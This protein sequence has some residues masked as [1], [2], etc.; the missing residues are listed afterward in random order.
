MT[1]SMTWMCLFSFFLTQLLVSSSNYVISD[2][3]FRNS[4]YL[5][6]PPWI[7]G[8][9]ILIQHCHWIELTTIDSIYKLWQIFNT[10]LVTSLMLGKKF[11][12]RHIIDYCCCRLWQ[13]VRPCPWSRTPC[14]D[15]ARQECTTLTIYSSRLSQVWEIR[16][17]GLLTTSSTQVSCQGTCISNISVNVADWIRSP[18]HALDQASPYEDP[19][20]SRI[21][22]GSQ[23]IYRSYEGLSSG[24]R[25]YEDPV[26]STSINTSESSRHC[27]IYISRISSG[28]RSYEDPVDQDRILRDHQ[29]DSPTDSVQ[30]L[31]LKFTFALSS[32]QL[33]LNPVNARTHTILLP[34]LRRESQVCSRQTWVGTFPPQYFFNTLFLSSHMYPENLEKQWSNLK[35][36]EL[37]CFLS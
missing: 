35:L 32:I 3:P 23:W 17:P 18:I 34:L 12:R 6:R 21:I 27:K 22:R 16:R 2:N 24:S 10:G 20:R 8:Y 1:W 5:L 36:Y 19:V 37:V 33:C 26:L 31:H 15:P 29:I 9:D 14:L 4:I 28:S 25:S 7:M 11:I 30:N 13:A